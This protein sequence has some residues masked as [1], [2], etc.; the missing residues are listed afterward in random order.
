M[1]ADDSRCTR[2]PYLPLCGCDPALM[3]GAHG[4]PGIRARFNPRMFRYASQLVGEVLSREIQHAR[5]PEIIQATQPLVGVN[6]DRKKMKKSK[7]IVKNR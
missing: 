6:R 1:R 4:L 5:L 2:M 7:K 3:G